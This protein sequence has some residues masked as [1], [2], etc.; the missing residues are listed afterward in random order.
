MPVVNIQHRLKPPHLSPGFKEGQQVCVHKGLTEYAIACGVP[1]FVLQLWEGSDETIHVSGY[2]LVE[3]DTNKIIFTDHR[4][5]VI[6]Y[7]I[8]SIAYQLS[9]RASHTSTESAQNS[10]ISEEKEKDDE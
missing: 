7:M 1:A 8:E 9:K 10:S 2:S 5:D 4:H 6:E 3:K